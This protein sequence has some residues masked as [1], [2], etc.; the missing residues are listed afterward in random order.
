MRIKNML[1]NERG[2]TGVE[3]GT[4]VTRISLDWYPWNPFH[5]DTGN[6][7]VVLYKVTWMS[8]T[9]MSCHMTS[10]LYT[11]KILSE[12]TQISN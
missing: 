7:P 10:S 6:G 1:W 4:D 8:G 11:V 12:A 9:R 2:V 3:N 5:G